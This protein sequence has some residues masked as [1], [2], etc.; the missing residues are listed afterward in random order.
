MA[1]PLTCT[2]PEILLG[3]C[4][5]PCL[6]AAPASQSPLLLDAVS[7]EPNASSAT[8]QPHP[9]PHR[10]LQDS[11]RSLPSLASSAKRPTHNSFVKASL[12]R[13]TQPQV[14]QPPP[15]SP[16]HPWLLPPG[17]LGEHWQGTSHETLGPEESDLP[18]GRLEGLASPLTAQSQQNSPNPGTK[19][20][21][22][23]VLWVR[24]VE[25]R[26][27]R[28]CWVPTS[29]QEPP[30]RESSGQPG[31]L[32]QLPRRAGRGGRPGRHRPGAQLLRGQ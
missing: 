8:P 26:A 29:V 14:P 20:G 3:G 25:E 21:R 10:T 5:E 18:G 24:G 19:R 7:A 16:E 9:A 17:P 12:G 23:G 22:A 2:I 4:Q 13:A 28:L 30:Q 1:S 27:G 31:A 11:C 15:P 6:L 32:L